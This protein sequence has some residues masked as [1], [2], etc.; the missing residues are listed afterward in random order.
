MLVE[1]RLTPKGEGWDFITI[2]YLVL[3]LNVS[4]V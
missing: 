1:N 2:K 3:G 4:T